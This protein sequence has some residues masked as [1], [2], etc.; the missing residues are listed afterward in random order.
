MKLRTKFSLSI[1]ALITGILVAVAGLLYIAE[2]RHLE[3]QLYEK[4]ETDVK[5]FADVAKESIL[6]N[7]DIALLNYVMTLKN[8]QGVH[9]VAFCD[10]ERKVLMHSDLSLRGKQ[11]SD[12]VSDQAR[13]ASSYKTIPYVDESG[14]RM[15]ETAAPVRLAEEKLGTVR[16]GYDRASLEKPIQ[17]MLYATGRRIAKIAVAAILCG[18]IVAYILVIAFTKPIQILSEGARIIGEG[19]L[20]HRI[21]IT[22]GDELGELSGEFNEMAKKLKEL[23][24]M[25]DDFVDSVSHE[26]RSPLAAIRGFA[27]SMRRG[28]YGSVNEKQGEA[29][30]IVMSNSERLGAFVD[31]V[32]DIAKIKAGMFALAREEVD[33]LPIAEDIIKMFEPLAHEMQLSLSVSS[34]GALAK[35]YADKDKMKH[36]ITNLVSNAMKFTP[37]GGSITVK[38]TK[39][40]N[41]TVQVEVRDTGVGIPKDKLLSVFNKFEQVE[42]TQQLSKQIKGTGL[43]LTIAKNIV[44]LHGGAIW[45]ESEPGKGTSFIFTLPVKPSAAPL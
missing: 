16:I 32:L 34:E 1:C 28:V 36:V 40:D 33:F 17:D 24:T 14:V 8:G 22:G 45:V 11:L 37:S 4:L 21:P 44:D 35:V 20:D 18:I 26:L 6:T 27:Q 29:L 39:K 38:A 2:K 15:M 3:A 5:K 30:D 19:N 9:Y 31:D 23:D 25:K 13:T 41:G 42:G 12:A 10:T 7:Q 43:G